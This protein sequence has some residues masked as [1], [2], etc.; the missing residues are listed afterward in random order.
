[1]VSVVAT[2]RQKRR[3]NFS[4]EFKKRLAQQACEPGASVSHLAQQHGIN[5]NMLFKWRR[6]LIAGLFDA[7]ARSQIM[8]PV[9]IV[10]APASIAPV[11]T[12]KCQATPV[13]LTA[14][15]ADVHAGRH[16][17]IEIQIG[18]PT[19]RVDGHAD[20]ATLRSVI[21]MLRT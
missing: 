2:G 14:P 20:L 9:A 15:A 17:V 5:V 7:P 3:P 21:R 6:H 8:L 12:T 1:V 19:I 16:G 13:P 10:E 18:D 4:I 11:V